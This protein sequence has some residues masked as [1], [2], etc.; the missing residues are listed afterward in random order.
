[1][2]SRCA[3]LSLPHALGRPRSPALRPSLREERALPRSQLRASLRAEGVAALYLFGST[4]R[5]QAR[6][7]SD[8]DLFFDY[9]NPRFSLVELVRVKDRVMSILGVDVPP[10]LLNSVPYII[11]IIVVA[12]VVGR[13]RGPAAAGQPYKQG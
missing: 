1:M 8:V 12:G 3:S 6:V 7:G 5:G 4:A 10:Q 9:D 11:T 2:A 13:V